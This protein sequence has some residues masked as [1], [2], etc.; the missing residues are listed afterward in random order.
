MSCQACKDAQA[1]FNRRDIFVRVGAADVQILA[2][3][4][5]VRQLIDLVRAAAPATATAELT[6]LQRLEAVEA[7]TLLAVIGV[8]RL[9][10]ELHAQGNRVAGQL[11]RLDARLL[12][13]EEKK[14]A[15]APEASR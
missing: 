12:T 4:D 3:D 5:H 14:P 7:R 15:P 8:E 10:Q 11:M 6:P 2:C 13:L 9:D 1:P